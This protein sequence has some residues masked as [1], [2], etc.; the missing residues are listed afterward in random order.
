MVAISV[1]MPFSKVPIQKFGRVRVFPRLAF[2][3]IFDPKDADRHVN[4]AA[5]SQRF[6]LHLRIFWV[7]PESGGG[8]YFAFHLKHM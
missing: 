2:S 7:T 3:T 8:V 1:Y 4:N 5:L 6:L